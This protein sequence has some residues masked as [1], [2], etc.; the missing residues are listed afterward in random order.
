MRLTDE[1]GNAG[2]TCFLLRV[3]RGELSSGHVTRNVVT[4]DALGPR[5]A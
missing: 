5:G 4:R 1:L 3:L 2:L